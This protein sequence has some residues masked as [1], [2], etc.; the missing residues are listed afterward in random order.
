M[1][2]IHA[3]LWSVVS[4]LVRWYARDMQSSNSTLKE[5]KLLHCINHRTYFHPWGKHSTQ[6]QDRYRYNEET[7]E[8][9]D[10]QW[11]RVLQQDIPNFIERQTTYLS[12]NLVMCGLQWSPSPPTAF[13]REQY[14]IQMRRYA[15][16]WQW[17]SWIAIE[18]TEKSSAS[19]TF[20]HGRTEKTCNCPQRTKQDK[21]ILW[22]G[23]GH[24]RLVRKEITLK[25]IYF[26]KKLTKTDPCPSILN[27]FIIFEWPSWKW[28]HY[29]NNIT[30]LTISSQTE[31]CVKANLKLSE[32]N[33]FKFS[34]ESDRMS[35]KKATMGQQKNKSWHRMR[36]L[37]VTSENISSLY[38]RQKT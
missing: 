6:N 18:F 11:K 7:S 37:L 25:K 15:S 35:R 26:V 1:Q 30:S 20:T 16:R 32:N 34:T 22:R 19:I 29:E 5:E 17:C 28:K 31:N 8:I 33:L 36:H 27:F 14:G 4:R 21:E 10:R 2:V 23:E 13:M 38:T 9:A 24:I 3:S 12:L